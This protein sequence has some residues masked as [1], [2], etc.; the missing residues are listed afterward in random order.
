MRWAW[1]SKQNWYEEFDFKIRLWF[2]EIH[3]CFQ[4]LEKETYGLHRKNDSWSHNV[5]FVSVWEGC[6]SGDV[7]S[8][9]YSIAM[10]KVW[11]KTQSLSWSD[12]EVKKIRKIQ[13]NQI[14]W[15]QQIS[16]SFSCMFITFSLWWNS[17][18]TTISRFFTFKRPAY[19]ELKKLNSEIIFLRNFSWDFKIKRRVK[20]IQYWN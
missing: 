17:L 4:S 16:Q 13:A 12:L 6:L 19:L 8:I 20:R 9:L 5:R 1:L 11:K 15:D 2:K 3:K 18:S 14:V 10:D 7:F